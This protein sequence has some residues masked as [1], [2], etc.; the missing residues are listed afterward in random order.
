[1]KKLVFLCAFALVLMCGCSSGDDKFDMNDNSSTVNPSNGFAPETLKIGTYVNWWG[2]QIIDGKK[3]SEAP[4]VQPNSI[5]ILNS[6]D[7]LAS[8]SSD[9]GTYTYSK[10]GKNTATLSFSI[11]QSL[12]G[13]LRQFNYVLNL[14]YKNATSFKVGGRCSIFST[15]HGNIYTKLDCVGVMSDKYGSGGY[16]EI[17]DTENNDAASGGDNNENTTDGKDYTGVHQGH[18][19]VDLGLSVKWATCNVGA[20]SPEESGGYYAWGETEEKENYHWETY[21]WCNGSADSMT[22]YCA[23]GE[24]SYNVVDNKTVLE[25]N[26]DVAHVKWGGSWR[27]PTKEELEELFNQDNC[28]WKSTTLNDKKGYKITSKKNGASIFFPT[29]YYR[30]GFELTTEA[31]CRNYWTSTLDVAECD[32]AYNTIFSYGG[33]FY[34]TIN[35]YL[36]CNGHLVRPVCD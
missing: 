18:Q 16:V 30:S 14:T 32:K 19:W 20:D 35:S 24:Y 12:P 21:K 26:D 33:I 15:M 29:D 9:W 31:D 28:I 8:W 5:Q 34:Y 7:C 1:M 3:Y 22:K 6:T 4:A 2:T 17:P 27:M 10:T 36:R 23:N 25:S 13:H 11:V